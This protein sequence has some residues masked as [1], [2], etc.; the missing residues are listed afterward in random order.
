M[1]SSPTFFGVLEPL[2]EL[3]HLLEEHS[4]ALAAGGV[5][6]PLEDHLLAQDV[7]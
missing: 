4:L 2:D 3:L 1:T 7:S 5:A 6:V